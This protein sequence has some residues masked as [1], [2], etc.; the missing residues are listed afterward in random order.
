MFKIFKNP[1]FKQVFY[2][3]LLY[4]NPT[5]TANAMNKKRYG[6]TPEEIFRGLLTKSYLMSSLFIFIVYTLVFLVAPLRE[7]PYILDYI[8]LVFISIVGSSKVLPPNSS[9]FCLK[10]LFFF[11][12]LVTIIVLPNRGFLS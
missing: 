11:L 12:V 9:I 6:D 5:I 3:N 1:I 8:L 7:A 2:F 4:A 10:S